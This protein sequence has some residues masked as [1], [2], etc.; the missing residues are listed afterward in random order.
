MDCPVADRLFSSNTEYAY[1][2]LNERLFWCNTQT[3]QV[4]DLGS[5]TNVSSQAY[6]ARNCAV[7]VIWSQ[8]ITTNRVDYYGPDSIYCSRIDRVTRQWMDLR[9]GDND[10]FILGLDFNAA[11]FTGGDTILAVSGNRR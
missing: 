4:G 10:S 1:F 6:V 2:H 9:R 8:M 3:G 11:C 7:Y 5:I